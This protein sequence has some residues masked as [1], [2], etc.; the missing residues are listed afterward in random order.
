MSLSVFD[1]FDQILADIFLSRIVIRQQFKKC[2]YYK[3]YD[4]D[5]SL[6]IVTADIVGLKKL[7]LLLYHVDPLGVIV[8]I[9]PVTDIH[10]VAVYR[11]LLARKRIINEE[12]YQLLGEL[13][14]T[15]II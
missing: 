8:H 5:V 2:L 15:V 14:R 3:I 7:S 13:I 1:V 4:L 9:K 10:S 11:K 6:L 12:R